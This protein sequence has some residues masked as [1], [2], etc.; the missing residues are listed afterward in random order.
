MRVGH[1]G[2]TRVLDQSSTPASSGG[3]R[4]HRVEQIWR[5]GERLGYGP[6]KVKGVAHAPI[7]SRSWRKQ[8]LSAAKI[9]WRRR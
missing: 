7:Q 8:V 5:A 1:P 3:V 9:N 6:G 2:V 4:P